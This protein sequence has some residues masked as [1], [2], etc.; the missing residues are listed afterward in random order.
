M[1]NLSTIFCL[2]LSF[3]AIHAQ[4]SVMCIDVNN[5]KI[6]ILVDG[7]WEMMDHY[8]VLHLLED[9]IYSFFG[10]HKKYP[11]ALKKQMFEK[12]TEYTDVLVPKFQKI[13]KDLKNTDYAIL[14]YLYNNNDYNVDKRIFK[15]SIS[16]ITPDDLEFPNTFTFENFYTTTVPKAAFELETGTFCGRPYKRRFFVTPIISEEIAIDV[17]DAMRVHPCPY[18]LLFV[19]NIQGV[20]K[21]DNPLGFE[22]S[23]IRTKPKE[24]Y[25]YNKD[26]GHVV[27]DMK[28]VL[29]APNTTPNSK[30]EK[31]EQQQLRKKST[32]RK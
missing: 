26:T 12:T 10:L 24:I 31:T 19:V 30:T 21:Q 16:T 29:T 13:K 6:P 32:T 20:T 3:C 2:L 18:Y 8:K 4:N 27:V 15:F 11:S 23:Y 25:L 7:E 9:D 22:M 17:E 14:Y 1:K 28:S 5:D